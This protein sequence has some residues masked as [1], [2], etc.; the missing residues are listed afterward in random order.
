M[1]ASGGH[2]R[3][4]I[5]D[6]V[7]VTL[8]PA[9][10][11]PPRRT[12][13]VALAR[14]ENETVPDPLKLGPFFRVIHGEAAGADQRQPAVVVTRIDPIPVSAPRKTLVRLSVKAQ[15]EA[16]LVRLKLAVCPNPATLAVTR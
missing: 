8:W 10:V 2:L 4:R 12:A 1:A 5:G 15:V 11:I 13:P 9:T 7:T 6:W 14:Y 3:L 16:V